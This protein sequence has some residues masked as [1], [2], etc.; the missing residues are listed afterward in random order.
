MENADKEYELDVEREFNP[1][2]PYCGEPCIP[3]SVEL[4]DNSGWFVGWTCNC[5]EIKELENKLKE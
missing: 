2:C 1:E 5:K 3:V 4:E